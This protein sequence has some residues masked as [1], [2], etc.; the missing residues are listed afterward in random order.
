M[1]S[2]RS[3]RLKQHAHIANTIGVM[4]A[5]QIR[6][7]LLLTTLIAIVAGTAVASEVQT[8]GKI[9]VPQTAPV[10]A[11]CTDPVVQQT[12]EQDFHDA[13]RSPDSGHGPPVTV[14]VTLNEKLLKPGVVLGDLGPGDP[15]VIARLM[16]AAGT[17]PPPIGDTGDKPLDPY[18]EAARRQIMD[19][20]DPMAGLRNYQSFRNEMRRPSEPRFG[21]NGN[22]SDAE[23]YDRV[24][25]ARATVGGSPDQLMALVVVHPRDDVRA[26]K[27]LIAEEIANSILH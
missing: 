3:G 6:P 5:F 14:T 18:S 10:F 25:V 4:R 12:L 9:S 22:A 17:D 21:P 2:S 11:V 15:W 13:H 19:P 23:I 20:N 8:D 7:A 27:E 1:R 26:A 16:R 24:I